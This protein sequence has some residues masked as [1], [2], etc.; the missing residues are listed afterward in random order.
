MKSKKMGIALLAAI[1]VCA[2]CNSGDVQDGKPESEFYEVET[3]FTPEEMAHV[4]SVLTILRAGG[5]PVGPDD[6][7]PGV[8]KA[9]DWSYYLGVSVEEAKE[10]VR[11]MKMFSRG[12]STEINKW[13]RENQMDENDTSKYDLRMVLR[14]LDKEDKR[15]MRRLKMPR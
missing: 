15:E 5:V 3:D 9:A 12:D 10:T 6:A 1:V 8:Y 2:G 4:D 11:I 13:L 7:V 14:V